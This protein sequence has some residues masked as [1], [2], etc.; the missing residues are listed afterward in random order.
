MFFHFFVFRLSLQYIERLFWKK[1]SCVTTKRTFF[2]RAL[3]AL[4]MTEKQRYNQLRKQVAECVE[5]ILEEKGW[6]LSHFAEE[7]GKSKSHVFSI[8]HA[9]ANLTLRVIAEMEHTLGVEII[10]PKIR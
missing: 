3:L 5:T 9:N 4:N 8:L 10:H 6:S 1:V 7:L 2:F